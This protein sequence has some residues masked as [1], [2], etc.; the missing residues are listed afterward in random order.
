MRLDQQEQRIQEQYQQIQELVAGN[1]RLKTF[2]KD[3]GASK[4]SKPPKF[5]KSYSVDKHK[6]RVKVN[7]GVNRPDVVLSTA[8]YR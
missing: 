8:S 6:G 5:T 4:G 3:K 1:E 2:L 7:E